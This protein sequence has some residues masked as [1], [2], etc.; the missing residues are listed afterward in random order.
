MSQHPY[1]PIRPVSD[2]LPD[3]TPTYDLQP[4]AEPTGNPVVAAGKDVAASAKDVAASARD[5]AAQVAGEAG[6]QARALLDTGVSELRQ[7]ASTAQ[8]RLAGTVRSLADELDAMRG[9]QDANGPLTELAGSAQDVARR[10]ADWLEQ[11][12]PDDALRQAR[13]YAA[14]NPMAFLAL[15]AGAGLIV[16]RLTR[17]LRDAASEDELYAPRTPPV[18]T[19][20]RTTQWSDDLG[21]RVD[22]TAWDEDP[23]DPG[24]ARRED[25]TSWRGDA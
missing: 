12:E 23:T 10:T 14:R 1:D 9:A 19:R 6:Y 15:A 11:H 8:H 25:V 4:A 22:R 17:N 21:T 3:E 13:R 16:G 24:P 7:Q 20:G 5:E 18:G 2:P